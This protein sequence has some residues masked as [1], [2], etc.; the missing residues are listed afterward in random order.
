[1]NMWL[2]TQPVGYLESI[3]LLKH[4]EKV[5]TN[6]AVIQCE[7][8]FAGKQCVTVF[9]RVIWPQDYRWRMRIS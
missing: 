5:V 4:C 8:F 1:M 2:V 6:M 9:D 3:Q 7:A